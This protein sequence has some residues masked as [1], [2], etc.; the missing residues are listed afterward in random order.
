MPAL[1]GARETE[2]EEEIER[3]EIKKNPKEVK[4]T[5]TEER[6]RERER[7]RETEQPRKTN[8]LGR[9][10]LDVFKQKYQGIT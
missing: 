5:P 9:K 3:W 2:E 8:N 7:E 10:K 4:R 6:E 1:I